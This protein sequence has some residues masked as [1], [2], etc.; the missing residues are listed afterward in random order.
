MKE[1]K[2][3]NLLFLA[4]V[5]VTFTLISTLYASSVRYEYD[6]L[7]RLTRAVYDETTVI[8]YTYDEVGNRNR[9]VS[10]L[11]ADTSID[12]SVNFQDFAIVA[13]RW[14]D[15]GCAE[16][17]WCQGADINRNTVVGFEDLIQ[18]THQ[19]LESIAP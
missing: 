11:I 14:L 9:R 19:W 7:N 10:T 15:E 8:E 5:A 16:P 13:A 1:L 2:Q 18:L 3:R 6:D 17:D 4:I 12:G